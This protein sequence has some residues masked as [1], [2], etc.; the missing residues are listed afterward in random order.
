MVDGTNHGVPVESFF[1]SGFP[2]NGSPIFAK[3]AKKSTALILASG[4]FA[5]GGGYGSPKKDARGGSTGQDKGN[6]EIGSQRKYSHI[7]ERNT[8]AAGFRGSLHGETDDHQ[9]TV[10]CEPVQVF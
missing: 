3:A 7:R 8:Y 10:V 4:C 5:L 6:F 1:N 9:N 2:K